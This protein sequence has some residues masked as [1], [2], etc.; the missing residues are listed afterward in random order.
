MESR[1]PAIFIADEPGLDF[2]N[3]IATP[4]EEPVDWIRDGEGYLNWLE[5]AR[6]APTGALVA[7]RAQ[8]LPGELDSVA[9]RARNLREWFRSF[10]LSHK[11]RP[12]TDSAYLDLQPLNHLLERDDRLS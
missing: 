12:L 9:E 3:S 8:A 11:G 4:V 7:M 10:V 6:L 1:P 2:L 5:Q